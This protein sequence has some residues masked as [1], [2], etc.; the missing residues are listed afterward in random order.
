MVP[1]SNTGPEST[2]RPAG[3]A[4]GRIGPPHSTPITA[5]AFDDHRASP[6]AR[7]A[8][9]VAA[10]AVP[11]VAPGIAAR[12][13]RAVT[14]TR[15]PPPAGTLLH[16]SVRPVLTNGGVDPLETRLAVA[17]GPQGLG[18]MPVR[19]RPRRLARVTLRIGTALAAF[20]GYR[21][22]RDKQHQADQKTDSHASHHPRLVV[23][24]ATDAAKARSAGSRC[25]REQR[26]DSMESARRSGDRAVARAHWRRGRVQ[27]NNGN[28]RDRIHHHGCMRAESA[29][30]PAASLRHCIERAAVRAVAQPSADREC[31][32][33]A[34]RS[35]PTP[36]PPRPARVTPARRGGAR[37][38][39]RWQPD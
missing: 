15:L 3:E 13:G 35:R 5:S 18:R 6:A 11:A 16:T 2:R 38:S 10:I 23:Y 17:V 24:H 39:N 30:R 31:R 37:R 25:H 1:D 22:A 32:Y 21:Y 19:Q 20:V 4:A 27:A 14:I 12:V 36:V 28:N 33:G 29:R 7:P 26:F 34:I 8:A 9:F